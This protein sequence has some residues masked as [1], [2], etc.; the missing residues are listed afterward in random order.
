MGPSH[1]VGKAATAVGPDYRTSH[2][3]VALGDVVGLV[4]HPA[5]DI[6]LI[7]GLLST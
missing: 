5:Q 1:C 6:P 3:T 4:I 7:G 2:E